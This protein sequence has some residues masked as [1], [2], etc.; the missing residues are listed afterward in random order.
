MSTNKPHRHADILLAIAEG[1]QVQFHFR[2]DLGWVDFDPD[3]HVN[4]ITTGYDYSWRVKP[5]PKPDVVRY[6]GVSSNVGY[7]NLEELEEVI[8][9]VSV[10]MFVMKATFCGENPSVLKSIERVD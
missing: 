3:T 7:S 9:F 10:P 8:S 5:E 2:S 4:P 6:F 1:K